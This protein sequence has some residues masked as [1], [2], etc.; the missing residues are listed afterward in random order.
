MSEV[1]PKTGDSLL[2][3]DTPLDNISSTT[4]STTKSKS[5][6]SGSEFSDSSSSLNDSPVE[7]IGNRP[8]SN[9]AFPLTA[10]NS[11]SSHTSKI[12]SV[13]IR[14]GQQ[15]TKKGTKSSDA[16]SKTQSESE[17]SKSDQ[18]DT[19]GSSDNLSA[20][21]D[22]DSDSV[23]VT[24]ELDEDSKDTATKLKPSEREKRSETD[25]RVDLLRKDRSMEGEKLTGPRDRTIQ[26][27]SKKV[28]SGSNTK[29]YPKRPTE[30]REELEESK[31]IP[32]L[33]E[34]EKE[35]KEVSL[36]T[37]RRETPRTWKHD[38]IRLISLYL[39]P[40]LL[41][42]PAALLLSL[43]IQ[44]LTP[45]YNSI[46]LS[47]HTPPLYV[48]YTAIAALIYWY[49]TSRI[50]A[51]DII[52]ARICLGLVALSGDILAVYGRR[53]GSIS[54]RL[55]G[56]EYGAIASRALMGIGVVGGTT[57]FGLLCFDHIS[58]IPPSVDKTDRSR[59]LGSVLYRSAFYVL[60]IY[61]FERLW[62]TY[63]SNNL[64]V[65]NGNPE[66]TILFI[67]LILTALSLFLKSSTS[68]TPFPTRINHLVNR[69]LKLKSENAKKVSNITNNILPRQ[70]FPLLLLIRIPFLVLALRQQIFL[71]PPSTSLQPYI[72][73]NG[74]L[75]V[76]SSEKSITG[77][78][79][80]A[81]NLKDGYRFLRCDHS[82]LGGRWI[83]EVEDKSKS[84]GKRI[85]MGDSIFA[86]FNLQE[87]VV[88]AH[89]SDPSESLIKTLQL[90][91]DLEV[92][93][94]GENHEEE[95]EIPERALIIGLGAGIA[96]ST[97]SRRGMFGTYLEIDPAVYLASHH[98]FGLSSHPITSTNIM[99]G[100]LF[101]SQ[102]AEMK[103]DNFTDHNTIPE[104]DYVV[105][106]CFTGGSV[107][108]EMFTREFWED[109]GD[110]VK[111]DG[112]IA[113][114]FAGVLG[115][116]ASKAVL[117]TLTSVFPQCRA[118]GDS[119][120]INQGPND[121]INMVVICTKTYSPL[122]TFR[123]P[124]LNDIMKSPLRS[125]IYSNFQINEIYLND[126]INLNDFENLEYHLSKKND[127]SIKELNKWQ[128]QS[129]FATWRA[130]KNILTPEMW[131]AW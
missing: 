80:V 96:A 2:T 82:I 53:I 34:S 4:I 92:S 106:D 66:K 118:F 6:E 93:L 126:I 43:N 7:D 67:S 1:T 94:E 33:G 13:P 25:S 62:T 42:I 101:I 63:L 109:L 74:E 72:T 30:G 23:D 32:R 36:L 58:H 97:F 20:S 113:M 31:R 124:I 91:T 76:I 61:T 102:L 14:K 37:K 119:F 68:S 40:V 17:L 9:S 84:T 8:E 19:S 15:A 85:D 123:K 73:A 65:L 90:T 78:I 57:I 18:D 86:T 117:V 75:R 46:P 89:R 71:R 44:L 87:I 99:D 29:V 49:I 55:L 88:L 50:P 26:G 47:L 45:L 52:S 125:H 56:A 104:W 38:M 105:Q 54:G 103:R 41:G 122:L 129:S 131:L 114:N 28:V 83:R 12:R 128:I 115:S 21:S 10:D 5:T 22:T 81:E 3:I 98:H 127:K 59:S 69:S 130:M 77:Q 79:V 120:E 11:S 24:T 64:S 16:N 121:L 48:G 39:V 111:D 60:H 116:K 112:I 107:P 27:G 100:S 95:D 110:L 108:G 70:A 35:N 51:K